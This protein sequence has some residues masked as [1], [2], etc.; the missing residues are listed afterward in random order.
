MGAADVEYRASE[1]PRLNVAGRV[2]ELLR[3]REV[4]ANLTGRELKV[5]YKSTVLGVLWSMLNPLLY[6]V[7]FFVVFT[8]FLPSGIPRFAVYLLSGL[9]GYT[10]YSTGLLGATASVVENSALVTK[11]AFPR[12]ILPLASIGS[13]LVNFFYQFAVLLLFIVAIGYP[14]LG[15]NLVLV[16]A[17]LAVLL[18]FMTA[19]GLGTAA[20][21]V[22][23]RDTRHLVELALIAWFW[24]TPIV[25]PASVVLERF[26]AD[27]IVPR[28]YLANP[29]TVVTLAF[30]RALYGGTSPEAIALLP[31]PGLSW[32]AYRLGLLAAA[33]ALLLSLTWWAFF[34]MSGDFAEEL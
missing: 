5:K 14:F 30:Q 1:P 9:L 32:Y 27:S 34:R 8:F 28:L 21:N 2:R 17:A 25:Y 10:M 6:L 24:A 12:E 18:L 31:D 13:S 4:L 26:G 23:Y 29:L 20:L 19:L 15:V 7:V 3:Y 33:S 11:V 22:R 16:P